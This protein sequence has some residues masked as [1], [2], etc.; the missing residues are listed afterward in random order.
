MLKKTKDFDF[1]M[2][3]IKVNKLALIFFPIL[4]TAIKNITLKLF[5]LFSLILF[6]N[7]KK[8]EIELIYKT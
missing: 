3:V 6:H 1:N 7:L 4:I 5:S 8:K 2:L